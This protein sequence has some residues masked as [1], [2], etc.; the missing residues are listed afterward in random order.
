MKKCLNWGKMPQNRL[1]VEKRSNFDPKWGTENSHAWL[2]NIALMIFKK[3]CNI[4]T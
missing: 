3:I 2:L 1:K 4:G